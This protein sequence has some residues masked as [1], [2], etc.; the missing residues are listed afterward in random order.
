MA[1]DPLCGDG[2]AQSIR[3]AILAA[4][5]LQ[6]LSRGE[7]AERLLSHYQARLA[8]GL[9]RHLLLCEE[10]Y[11]TGGEGRWWKK[12]LKSTRQGAEWCAQ[13]VG[14]QTE[15]RYQLQGFEL[16]PVG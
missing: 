3:E 15:F 14:E 4:A 1:F 7:N 8:A 9:S 16:Q 12:E 10:F 5:V 11:R 6:S 2:T 13:R